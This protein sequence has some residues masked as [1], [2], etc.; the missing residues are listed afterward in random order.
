MTKEEQNALTTLR[1]NVGKLSELVAEQTQVLQQQ[2]KTIEALQAERRALIAELEE[3][4]S[5]GR[6]AEIAQGLAGDELAREQALS[7]LDDIIE[8]VRQCLR[9]LERE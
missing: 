9:Q 1:Y 5:N 8:E 7:Y 3:W 2:A 6:M 4:R